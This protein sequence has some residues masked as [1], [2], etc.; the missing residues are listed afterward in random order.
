MGIDQA[1]RAYVA[2]GSE[3]PGERVI[4]GND[5]GPR[6]SYI[7]ATVLRMRDTTRGLPFRS[8]TPSG[9]WMMSPRTAVFSI[10]W[11]GVGAVDAASRWDDWAR[12]EYGQLQE[13]QAFSDGGL[14]HIAVIDGGSGYTTV[15]IVTVDGAADFATAHVI[16]GRV[17]SI[18]I[19]KRGTDFVNPVVVVSGNAKASARGSGF[20]VHHP[21]G[22]RRL[23]AAI[24]DGF[25]ERVIADVSVDYD[26]ESSYSLPAIDVIDGDLIYGQIRET[27]P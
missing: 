16:D 13:Q 21:V 14:S 22:F 1:V 7:Y 8:A 5:D 9:E 6:P 23:D 26:R 17:A 15:P 10:Q 24:D 27:V 2:E 25:V 12:S 20:G 4:P 11:L 3:I 19:L 18:Q